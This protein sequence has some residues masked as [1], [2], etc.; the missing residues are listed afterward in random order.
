M[1]IPARLQPPLVSKQEIA[2]YCQ[3]CNAI[4]DSIHR[5]DD[6]TE[7]LEKWHR[8]TCRKF[9]PHEFTT[10]YGSVSTED[11]VEEA[12]LPEPPF[13]DDLAFSELRSVL[14]ELMA[15][16]LPTPQHGYFL[17][18]LSKN[19]PGS[20]ISDL[21][22]WPNAWFQNE[23]LLHADLSADQI[24]AYAVLKSGR[25]VPG[26]PDVSLPYPMPSGNRHPE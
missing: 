10:Y 5:G 18:L 22:Y 4:E 1:S 24:L 20:G 8:R 19:L 7:L 26:K 3:L 16:S 14:E 25:D 12:L 13:V 6:V 15:A 2:D 21:I 17:G 23:E 9:E 11:F